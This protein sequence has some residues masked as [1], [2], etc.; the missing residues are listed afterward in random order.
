[1]TN[2]KNGFEVTLRPVRKQGA[3][4]VLLTGEGVARMYV[5]TEDRAK[6]IV[7]EVPTHRSYRAIPWSEIPEGPRLALEK[8]AANAPPTN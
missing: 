4:G 7:A 3:P 2:E 8:A 5:T 6:A 1:M